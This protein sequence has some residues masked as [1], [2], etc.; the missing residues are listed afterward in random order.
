MFAYSAGFELWLIHYACPFMHASL[1]ALLCMA[2]A[3]YRLYA[4]QVYT[5]SYYMYRYLWLNMAKRTVT[6]LLYITISLGLKYRHSYTSTPP[7]IKSFQPID[8]DI[9]LTKDQ[10]KEF[11]EMAKHHSYRDGSGRSRRAVVVVATKKWENA[12]VPYEIDSSV[13]KW[14]QVPFS[15]HRVSSCGSPRLNCCKWSVNALASR[16]WESKEVYIYKMQCCPIHR[17]W[18]ELQTPQH[19]WCWHFGY[20]TPN[21]S[22]TS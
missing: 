4:Y 1:P 2:T 17:L 22:F 18:H 7:E 9:L 8:G 19:W 3:E 20:S 21:R 5:T 16:C 10:M 11:E 15:A 14:A 12:V 13:G 6:F